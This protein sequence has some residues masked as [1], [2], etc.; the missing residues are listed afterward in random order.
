MIQT[1]HL[2]GT[3]PNMLELTVNPC[4]Q[5]CEYCYAKNWKKELYSVDRV[6]NDI[7]RKEQKQEGLTPWLIRQRSAIS[8]SNR[9][10][11]LTAPNWRE[12]LVALKKLGF[13]FCIQTKMTK[14]YKD[15]SDILDPEKDMIYQTITGGSCLYEEKNHL[16]TEEKI[17]AAKFFVRKGFKLALAVNPYMPDKVALPEVSKLIDTVK[18]TWAVS[19]PYHRGGMG[20]QRKH[21]KAEY[22]KEESERGM[23]FIRDHCRKRNIPYD[24]KWD[25]KELRQEKSLIALQGINEFLFNG[26]HF[27]GIDYLSEHYS[28]FNEFDVLEFT[29]DSYCNYFQRQIDYFSTCVFTKN[30]YRQRWITFD[31]LPRTFGIMDFLKYMWNH[32]RLLPLDW[33]TDDFDKD[34]NLIF[35]REKNDCN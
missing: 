17:Q 12:Y 14:E 13:N 9:S 23:K 7:L 35:V 10:D 21:F 22:P 11:I 15:L 32:R 6:I 24:I 8:I 19:R 2:F 4:T 33:W 16:T 30:C 5:G 3:L 28:N 34:G 29:F 1:L 20:V 31:E 25:D 27:V 18:P 26:N